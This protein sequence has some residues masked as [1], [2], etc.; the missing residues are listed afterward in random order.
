MF[1]IRFSKQV[2]FLHRLISTKYKVVLEYY[3][4]GGRRTVEGCTYEG[5][6]EKATFC[7]WK[8]TVLL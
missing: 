8:K 2:V 7:E 5:E 4:D 6:R 1:L 3:S